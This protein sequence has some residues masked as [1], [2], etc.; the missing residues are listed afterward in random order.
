MRRGISVLIFLILM[1]VM[2]EILTESESILNSVN[3]SL[4]VFKNNVFPSLFPFFVLSNIL[5]KCGVPEFMAGIFKGVMHC[6]F[7]IKGVCAFIFFMS[8]ISGNP[9][10]AKYTRELYLASKIN[11]YEA[12]KILCF[13][14]FSNPL[15]ILGTV[16]LLFLQSKSAGILILLCHY[17]GNFIIGFCMRW[18]HPSETENEKVSL[19]KSISDMHFKRVQNKESFGQMIISSISD[20]IDTLLLILGVITISLVLTTILD[21]VLT[22]NSVFQSVLNGFIEMTQGLKYISLEAIALKVKCIITVMIL[23][24][25]GFSV[26]MQIMGI[27]SDTDIPYL[28][29]LCARVCHAI[30]SSL[31]MFVLF[32]LWFGLT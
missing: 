24:F 4:N 18:W 28:P 12:I 32:D 25:G 3:F 31:L 5:I 8:I 23:S 10:N 15:F 7:K 14:M 2:F 9:A 13:T 21:N 22:L 30:I 11:R 19:K 1:F 16:A 17:T 27:L 29:F 26:H 6:F 20:S